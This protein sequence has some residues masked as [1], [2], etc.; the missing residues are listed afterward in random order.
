MVAVEHS[1]TWW[2]C[3]K[4]EKQEGEITEVRSTFAAVS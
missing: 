4:P 3:S 2:V 1:Q